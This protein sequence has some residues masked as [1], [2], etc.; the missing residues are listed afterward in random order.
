MPVEVRSTRRQNAGDALGHRGRHAAR[1]ESESMG[2]RLAAELLEASENR[3]AAVRKREDTA[4][5]GGRQQ[6]LR[7]YRW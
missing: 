1:S 3:G 2:Q 6:G 7:H 5:H 4:P